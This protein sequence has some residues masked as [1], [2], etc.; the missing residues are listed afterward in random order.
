MTNTTSIWRRRKDSL[1]YFVACSTVPVT[2]DPNFLRDL[3]RRPATATPSG[4]SPGVT[5]RFFMLK[6]KKLGLGNDL[7]LI[8]TRPTFLC[9]TWFQAEMMLHPWNERTHLARCDPD[10]DVPACRRSRLLGSSQQT[11]QRLPLGPSHFVEALLIV[12]GGRE[13]WPAWPGAAL[14]WIREELLW[15]GTRHRWLD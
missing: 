12:L 1:Y 5:S 4:Q 13:S 14:P 3:K 8:A 7:P 15:V 9:S 11:L 6:R 10:R 2:A